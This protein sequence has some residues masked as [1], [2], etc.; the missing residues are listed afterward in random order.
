MQSAGATSLSAP[1]AR[2]NPVV[3]VLLIARIILALPP[4]SLGELV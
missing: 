1:I 4:G 3:S 2:I